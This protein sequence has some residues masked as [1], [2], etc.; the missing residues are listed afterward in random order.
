MNTAGAKQSVES[1]F[2]GLGAHSWN[3]GQHIWIDPKTGE[4]QEIMTFSK[5]PLL[6]RLKAKKMQWVSV[7]IH[8]QHAV[9]F[10]LMTYFALTT[11][12]PNVTKVR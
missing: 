8:Y 11:C 10:L 3:R 2:M 9:L 4:K 6:D 5:K 12:F 7:Y 1:E